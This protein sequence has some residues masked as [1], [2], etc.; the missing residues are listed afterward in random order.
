MTTPRAGEGTGDGLACPEI[1]DFRG[2]KNGP[3]MAQL[4]WRG[5]EDEALKTWPENPEPAFRQD[6]QAATSIVGID[7]A[8][9]EKQDRVHPASLRTF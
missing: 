9:R 4:A 1:W 5:V 7:A 3:K 8:A 6:M 2:A